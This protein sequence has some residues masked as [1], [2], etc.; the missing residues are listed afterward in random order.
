MG[1]RH[2]ADL[3]STAKL[4]SGRAGPSNLLE[5]GKLMRQRDMGGLL[6]PSESRR[7][8]IERCNMFLSLIYFSLLRKESAVLNIR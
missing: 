8:F 3:S 7:G 1:F 5:I 4:V 2:G 6:Q